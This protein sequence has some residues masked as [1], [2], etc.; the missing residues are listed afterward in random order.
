[1]TTPF[2]GSTII[3]AHQHAAGAP[4]KGAGPC[5]GG[6]RR[7]LEGRAAPGVAAV[8]VMATPEASDS[9]ALAGPPLLFERVGK[10]L[11]VGFQFGDT[12]RERL[13]T[14]ADRLSHVWMVAKKEGM[15]LRPWGSVRRRGRP[16]ALSKCTFR[17]CP[18]LDSNQRPR[19]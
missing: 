10:P 13:A 12:P 7:L 9:L 19:D 17:R 16:E 5:G 2:V 8:A 4:K 11:H 6:T 3:R 1:V 14:G 18:R 15:Q